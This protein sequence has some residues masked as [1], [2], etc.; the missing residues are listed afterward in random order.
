M[1]P[2]EVGWR[3][4]SDRNAYEP[5]GSLPTGVTAVAIISYVGNAC[6]AEVGSYRGLAYALSDVGSYNWNAAVTAAESNNGTVV[7]PGTSGWFLPTYSQL[8]KICQG[9]ATKKKGSSVT[10]ELTT[11]NNS[12]YTANYLNSIITAAGGTGL[13]ASSYWTNTGV[14]DTNAWAFTFNNGKLID[15]Q[16]T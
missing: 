1:F 15:T 13:D 3:I 5:K 4:G 10:A 6:D 2:S 16:K 11:S 14:S 9:L 12:D 7:L 8:G